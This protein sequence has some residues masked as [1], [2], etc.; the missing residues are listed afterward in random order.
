[1]A[2]YV[3]LPIVQRLTYRSTNK[4]TA[5]TLSNLSLAYRSAL[6]NWP[7]MYCVLQ[8]AKWG[9]LAYY[10]EALCNKYLKD[11]VE[12]PPEIPIA[13]VQ[14]LVCNASFLPTISKRILGA[15]DWSHEIKVVSFQD[16]SFGCLTDY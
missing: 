12:F 6:R 9:S 15:N 2:D 13:D 10:P 8:A 7:V 1:M 14:K 4:I 3:V 11:L 5:F 16:R